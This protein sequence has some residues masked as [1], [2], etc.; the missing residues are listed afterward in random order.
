M[1]TVMK[2]ALKEATLTVSY[3][4]SLEDKEKITFSV[5]GQ[6]PGRTLEDRSVYFTAKAK[7]TNLTMW[8]DG[9]DSI[10]LG[11]A[12]IE[13]GN[14]ALK[15]NMYQHQ[16]THNYNKLRSFISDGLISKVVFKCISRSVPNHGSGYY[17]FTITPEFIVGRT[18][19]YFDNFMFEDVIHW[20]PFPSTFDSAME[21]IVGDVGYEFIDYDVDEERAA[22]EDRCV[23]FKED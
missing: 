9:E 3:P 23:D 18:P 10:A 13:H 17:L 14:F 22:F 11:L 16:L 2:E 4:Y 6:I 12:L 15:A 1:K 7:D 21:S 8:L 5:L 19:K 20:S